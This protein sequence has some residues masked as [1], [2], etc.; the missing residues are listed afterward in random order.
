MSVRMSLPKVKVLTELLEDPTAPHY[1][2]ELMRITGVKSG[3]LY[4]ILDQLERAGW[5]EAQW[6]ELREGRAGRPPRRWYRLTALGQAAAPS[7]IAACID[8][9]HLPRLAYSVYGAY[10]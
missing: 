1:G 6:E 10:R 3:S 8:A 4:P 5:L 7:A 2:Y 9:L